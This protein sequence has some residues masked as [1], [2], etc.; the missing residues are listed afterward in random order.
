MARV[1][2]TKAVSTCTRATSTLGALTG[3]NH[4]PECCLLN[5]STML[6]PRC[7][8]VR[9]VDVIP[10]FSCRGGTLQ[11][12]EERTHL[13]AHY[14]PGVHPSGARPREG[15]GAVYLRHGRGCRHG[16][17][18]R[19]LR[20]SVARV[21]S[22]LRPRRS[23]P[24][25]PWLIVTTDIAILNGYP[26]SPNRPSHTSRPTTVT[27][28]VL[29]KCLAIAKECLLLGVAVRGRDCRSRQLCGYSV[30]SRQQRER[31]TRC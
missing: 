20:S 10:M 23:P 26:N 19:T 14:E 8:V 6:I 21:A 28:V 4:N 15:F 5:H 12:E 30:S 11:Y 24:P 25:H 1:H 3:T 18:R 29:R 7:A 31:D 27:N 16:G 13:P 17:E 9:A 2:C 22:S